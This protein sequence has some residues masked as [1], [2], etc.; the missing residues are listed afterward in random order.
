[1]LLIFSDCFQC[2]FFRA[3]YGNVEQ[4]YNFNIQFHEDIK[5]SPPHIKHPKSSDPMKY[6]YPVVNQT[7]LL[8]CEKKFY[9]R[10]N[11][12]RGIELEWIIPS[13][14]RYQIGEQNVS[15]IL[16]NQIGTVYIL[17]Q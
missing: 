9:G 3:N 10:D 17:R 1:M 11:V 12:P 4:K 15:A 13:N 16:K 14:S 2:S 8:V 6:E 7:Y 5:V